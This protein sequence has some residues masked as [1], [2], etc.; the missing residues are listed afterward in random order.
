[1]RTKQNRTGI[2]RLFSKLS[3]WESSFVVFILYNSVQICFTLCIYKQF[4]KLFKCEK[5]EKMYFRMLFGRV[6]QNVFLPNKFSERHTNVFKIFNGLISFKSFFDHE[7]S[8]LSQ[9]VLKLKG[10]EKKGNHHTAQHNIFLMNG[11]GTRLY[12]LKVMSKKTNNNRQ[13]WGELQMESI[14]NRNSSQFSWNSQNFYPHNY[15]IA[16]WKVG[17]IRTV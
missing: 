3:E 9:Y 11:S 12:T 17:N 1:M 2:C 14:L 6:S 7:M 5:Y 10:Q 4:S 13:K 16:K 8:V 15:A